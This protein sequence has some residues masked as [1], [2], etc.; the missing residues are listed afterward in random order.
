MKKTLWMLFSLLLPVI[1]SAQQMPHTF[2]DGDL[3][4]AEEI[5]ANFEYLLK[6]AA[7]RKTTVDCS[8]G[9]TINAAL[10]KYNHI[11][12]SGICTENIELKY[13]ELVKSPLDAKYSQ[14]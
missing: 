7:I 13:D 9:E 3:I 5:N 14:I 4:Y 10:V 1:G 11:V 2:N 6:R 12:I 8:A